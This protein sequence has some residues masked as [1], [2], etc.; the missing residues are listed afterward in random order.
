MRRRYSPAGMQL[1]MVAEYD[2][3]KNVSIHSHYP[4]LYLYSHPHKVKK[5]LT[6]H[7][8]LSAATIEGRTNLLDLE[9][10]GRAISRRSVIDLG[11][12]EGD[13]TLMID[14]LVGSEGDA[15]T[16]GDG[17][18]AR[19]AASGSADVA[20][21]VVGRKGGHGGVVVGVCADILV[22]AAFGAVGSEV[23]EDVCNLGVSI[24][25]DM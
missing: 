8:P 18:G 19:A 24:Q 23:L 21:E 1:G 20:A 5:S 16:S 11:H 10:L 9:P 15:G 12:V 14:S 17:D 6:A 4:D 13:R 7:I 22:L 25:L 3:I 2:A